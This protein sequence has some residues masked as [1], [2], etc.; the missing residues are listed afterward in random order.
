M[1][2]GDLA[3]EQHF[4]KVLREVINCSTFCGLEKVDL[5]ELS[6]KRKAE[7]DL[8]IL[9]LPAKKRG[10]QLLF[11]EGLDWR[12]IQELGGAVSTAT[13]VGAAKGVIFKTN[14]VLFAEYGGH[15]VL[16]IRTRTKCSCRRWD[17]WSAGDQPARARTFVKYFDELMQEAIQMMMTVAIEEICTT[18]TKNWHQTGLNIIPSSS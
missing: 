11:G 12:V 4:S 7:E 3:A 14:Q 13:V 1:K 8:T 16:T 6:C 10:C 9:N 18:R 2:T 15:V 17:S 5:D